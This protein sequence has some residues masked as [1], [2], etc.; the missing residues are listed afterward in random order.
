TLTYDGSSRAAGVGLYLDGQPIELEIIRD[1]LT[2]EITGGGSDTIVIGERMRDSGFKNGLVDDFRVYNQTLTPAQISALAAG[3]SE[4]TADLPHYL[5]TVDPGYR[6]A[7]AKLAILRKERSAHVEKIPEIMVMEEMEAPRQ[8]YILERGL[9]STRGEPVSPGVPH[10]LP[11]LPEGAPNN[12]LGLAQWTV[13]ESNP[14]TARVTVNRYW[15]RLFLN[16]LV[17]TSEDFGSQGRLPTHPELLD[18][19]ARDF[20]E[21]DW[22][23]RHLLKQVVLSATYRQKSDITSGDLAT[24]D[25]GNTLLY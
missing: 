11:P 13:S 5:A 25:P 6:E 17:S 21:H 19:L 22:D 9:Y 16:G 4:F 8:T 12:R 2:R 24:Q 14:L 20:V 10:F 7:H 3:K 18:W 23:L 15:Q 1:K